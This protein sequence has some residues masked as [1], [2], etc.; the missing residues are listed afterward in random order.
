M[1]PILGARCTLLSGEGGGIGFFLA[2]Q[3][4]PTARNARKK[5]PPSETNTAMI[6]VWSGG[7]G[8]GCGPGVIGG[9]G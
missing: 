6:T 5:T 4:R 3:K 8:G 1:H 2:K 7:P 9:G